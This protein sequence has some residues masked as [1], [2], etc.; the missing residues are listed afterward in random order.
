MSLRARLYQQL[1]P[2][3]WPRAGL[4]PVNLCVSW[5][6]LLAVVI[7][8]LDT[9]P[10]VRDVAPQFFT[11]AEIVIVTIFTVEYLARVYCAGEDPQFAGLG[12]RLR[13]ARQFWSIIDLLTILPFFLTLGAANGFVLRIL[14]FFRLLRVA[15]MGR[16]THAFELLGQAIRA[17]RFELTITAGLAGLVLIF[18]SAMLYLVEAGEQPESFGSIPR[19]LW[20]SIATLTT[21]GYGDVA[22][23]TAIGRVL[24]G[25]TAVAGIGLIAMPTGILAA[26]FSEAIQARTRVTE[27]RIDKTAP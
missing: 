24:A 5:L 16:Y 25:V 12:G 19:A 17:R 14:R 21:V 10:V 26:A 2:S 8:V 20:W 27:Q 3:A 15:R 4:S 7:G 22:P 6:I 13:Y 18:S 23:V 1:E 9:E 11:W